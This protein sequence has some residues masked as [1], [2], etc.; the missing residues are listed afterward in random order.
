MT[1]VVLLLILV[2]SFLA[3]TK[4]NK[5]INFG[6]PSSS[7]EKLTLKKPLNLEKSKV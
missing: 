2:S 3:H 4:N 5:F 7:R 1:N 6:G